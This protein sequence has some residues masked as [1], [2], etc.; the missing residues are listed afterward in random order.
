LLV[1]AVAFLL[2]GAFTLTAEMLDQQ[3]QQQQ[4]T[5]PPAQGQ[6][7][8][9][10]Q[11]PGGGRQGGRGNPF[12]RPQQLPFPADAQTLTTSTTAIRVVPVASGLVNPWSLAFLPNGDILVTERAGRLRIVRGGTLDPEPIAGTPTVVAQGQGGLLEVALHP[13]FA[14]N[15]FIYLTYSKPGEQGNT[16][17]LA[18]GRFD[19][20]ALIDLQDIFVADA[21]S[22]QSAHFGSKIAFSPDGHLF[23]SVGERNDRTRAQQLTHHAGKIL[24]LNDDGSVPKDNPFAGKADVRPEIYSYGHRNAQ[25]LAFRPDTGELWATE[26]GPL[27]GDELNL[28]LP[29]RNYGWPV[30]TYGREYSG[31]LI[32]ENPFREGMEQPLT[33]WVPSIGLSGL[34]FYTG[35]AFPQWKGQLF[36]GG[37]SG[38][39]LNRVGLN[40]RGLAGREMLLYELRQ[41]IRDVRQGPDGFLY[42][43]TDNAKGG[44]L[45]IEPAPDKG[46]E[47]GLGKPSGTVRKVVTKGTE[48]GLWKTPGTVRD[49]DC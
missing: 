19:G 40:A 9:Q 32:A 25:G 31:E 46:T 43:V 33:V 14:Q 29:G 35:D 30:I 5:P 44:I 20:K 47:V 49:M 6:G 10:G 41:R 8:R 45:R 3:Q 15:Q 12:P 24:R 34:A 13:N 23:M 48:V 26:H 28:I 22:K 17:A 36:A 39:T 1:V 37:L 38:L 18:R 42:V 16:T 11:P 4:Q 7:A 2:T 27:G 21:W